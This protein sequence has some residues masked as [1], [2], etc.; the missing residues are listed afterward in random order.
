MGEG[1][2][3]KGSP[4]RMRLV[5][6][7]TGEYYTVTRVV[8][9]RRVHLEYASDGRPMLYGRQQAEEAIARA[10]GVPHGS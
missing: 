10:T 5:L 9:R 7:L 8:N 4:W 1:K 6:G 3:T 2:Q